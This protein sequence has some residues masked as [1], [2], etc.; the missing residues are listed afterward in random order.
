MSEKNWFVYM[1]KCADDSLYTGITTEPERRL[2][3]H[4]AGI[5]AKYTRCRLPVSMV[6]IQQVSDHSQALRTEL[7]IKKLPRSE[8]LKLI[9]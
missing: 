2:L 1:L 8:K 6:Y 3:Q 5:G 9:K 4:N 7:Q